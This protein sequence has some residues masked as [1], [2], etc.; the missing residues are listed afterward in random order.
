MWMRALPRMRKPPAFRSDRGASATSRIGALL[1]SL[2]IGAAF[3]AETGAVHT[4]AVHTGGVLKA[5]VFEPARMAPDFTLRGSNGSD[6]TLSRYRG[7]LVLLVFGY[8]S[9]SQERRGG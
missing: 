5:G 4:G 7:K 3:G 9:R 6:L 2:M 8:T 1:L